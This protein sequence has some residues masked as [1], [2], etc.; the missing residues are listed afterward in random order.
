MDERRSIWTFWTFLIVAVLVPL[1]GGILFWFLGFNFFT[2][3]SPDPQLHSL[4]WALLGWVG[5]TG[6]VLLVEF[7]I[8]LRQATVQ[9]QEALEQVVE[10]RSSFSEQVTQ[11]VAPHL[12]RLLGE[13]APTS[14]FM[15]MAK[16]L[17]RRALN[18][19]FTN[20]GFVQCYR[21]SDAKYC[22]L[23]REACARARES[24][25]FTC[26][27]TPYWFM[28]SRNRQVHL[29][30]MNSSQLPKNRKMRIAVLSDRSEEYLLGGSEEKY[31]EENRKLQLQAI[32][33]RDRIR[34]GNNEESEVHWFEEKNSNTTLLW[35]VADK[36][37][38]T[39]ASAAIKDF[40]I[41]D[42]IFYLSYDFEQGILSCAW[43]PEILEDHRTLIAEAKR[44]GA[45]GALFFE[46]F[47]NLPGI[48][49]RA[50]D[51]YRAE[52][53]R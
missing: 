46:S 20:E 34:W 12:V 43:N 36:L 8:V 38:G 10:A 9:V 45:R 27:E 11:A 24:I 22:D 30:A 16:D 2:A 48:D 41:F 53:T 7:I 28:L 42:G 35:T 18:E 17:T 25:V 40:G 52:Q 47:C 51:Q 50:R 31:E 23:L 1:G 26:L 32:L 3:G 5:I 4:A 33:A 29:E 21:V 6:L 49:A 37:I 39:V 15:S 44:V 13:A 19:G 14:T